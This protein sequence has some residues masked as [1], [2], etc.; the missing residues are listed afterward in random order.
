VRPRKYK[1][2]LSPRPWH[3]VFETQAKVK[4]MLR[5]T[6]SRPVCLGVKHPSGA[7][8][9]SLLLTVAGLLMRSA[10]SDE[11]TGISFTTAAGPRQ[12]SHSRVES[13][14]T[15]DHILLSQIRDSPN[16]KGQV[17]LFISP[18]NRVALILPDTGFPSRCLLRLA[19]LRWRYSNPPPRGDRNLSSST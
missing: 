17:P 4:V 12:R 6:F 9:R 8:T 11:R 14:G 15:H 3:S 19:G 1:G 10:V 13:R 2:E 7:Q 16:A 18:R 5:P